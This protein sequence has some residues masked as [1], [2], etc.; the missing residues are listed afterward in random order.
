[1]ATASGCLVTT[2]PERQPKENKEI[3]L[4]EKTGPVQAKTR[5]DAPEISRS[6]GQSDGIV[7]LWPRIA[8]RTEDPAVVELTR[9][10]QARLRAIALDTYGE[11]VEVRPMP[12]RV[13]PRQ[14]CT[15]PTLSAIVTVQGEACAVVA[16]LSSPGQS[17]T[18]LVPWA[19]GA[20][21]KGGEAP[22]REPP[23]SYVKV[24]E[25]AKCAD[26][27]KALAENAP[28]GDDGAVSKAVAATKK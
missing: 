1:M 20:E 3:H 17:P 28:L 4:S 8:P 5:D 13:C 18:R 10:V 27:K 7:V 14:G 16:T 9:L 12:E 24:T 11:K 19:G 26:L 23:E 15:A 21:V 2:A 6:V 25:F 22:F